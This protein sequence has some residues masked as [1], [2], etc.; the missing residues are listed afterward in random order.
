MFLLVELPPN[1]LLGVFRK[2]HGDL[3]E[4]LLHL[5]PVFFRIWRLVTPIGNRAS[6]SWIKSSFKTL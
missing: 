1:G 5:G 2:A 4:Q 6:S 3:A